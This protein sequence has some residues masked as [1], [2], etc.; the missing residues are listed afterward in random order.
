MI[1]SLS[2]ENFALIEKLNIDFSTGFS[3]ITGETGAGTFGLSGKEP[4]AAPFRAADRPFCAGIGFRNPDRLDLGESTGY[5]A[6]HP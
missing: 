3:V 6:C 2:I 4:F 1:I 5:S